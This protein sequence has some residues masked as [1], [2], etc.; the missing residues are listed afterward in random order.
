M[1]LLRILCV[2]NFKTDVI[3]PDP[4]T[5]AGAYIRVSNWIYE[6]VKLPGTEA[7]YSCVPGLELV[8]NTFT[9]SY[10]KVEDGNALWIPVNT[11]PK[12]VKSRLNVLF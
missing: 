3:C 1:L 7:K 8:P 2:L 4:P 5:I 6:G 9:H 11:L 10:C 12:C